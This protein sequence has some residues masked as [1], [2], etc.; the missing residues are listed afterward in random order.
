MNY[1]MSSNILV[2]AHFNDAQHNGFWDETYKSSVIE[3]VEATYSDVVL[4]YWGISELVMS[5]DK[6]LIKWYK[7]HRQLT[8]EELNK[9]YR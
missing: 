7:R 6:V 4:T 1:S 9:K 3:A 5:G 2:E 8:P